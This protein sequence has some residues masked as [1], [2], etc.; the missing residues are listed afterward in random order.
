MNYIVFDLEAT[1]WDGWDKSQNETIEIGAVLINDDKEIVSEFCK[2]IK[3]LKHPILSE[4]C[5]KLTSIQQSDVDNADYFGD[6]INEFQDWI[7][8]GDDDYI[9]CSWGFYDKKQFEADCDLNGLDKAWVEKHVSLKHQYG[10]FKKL[11]RAIGMKNTLLNENILLEGIHHRGIDDA[12]NI[13][14]IFIKYFDY[15]DFSA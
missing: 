7:R 9:L 13:A 2:F 14:K 8:Q 10:K 5:K 11:R 15:W 12:R 6:V 3:P 1:C 4:F